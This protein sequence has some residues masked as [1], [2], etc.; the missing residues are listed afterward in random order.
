MCSWVFV[1]IPILWHALLSYGRVLSTVVPCQVYV[2]INVETVIVHMQLFG[3]GSNVHY[4]FDAGGN[5]GC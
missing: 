3:H 2:C 4:F 5:A 1:H